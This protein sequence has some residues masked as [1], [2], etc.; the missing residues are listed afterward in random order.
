MV[1]MKSMMK[2]ILVLFVIISTF[3][4]VSAYTVTGM[5]VSP[6]GDF[7]PNTP[8]T[9]SFSIQ[10]AASGDETFP[11]SNTL[12]LATDLENPTW[13]ADLLKNGVSNPQPMDSKKI[14]EITGWILSYDPSDI[15]EENL[16][17]TLSGIAPEVT[18]TTDKNI[19]R[20][21][22]YDSR[23]NVVSGSEV[24]VTR[25]IINTKEITDLIASR[26]TD[27]LA[28]R[29]NI[30][31]KAALEVDIAEAEA[32]Y[33]EAQAAIN[34][35]KSRPS[36]EYSAALASLN[37]AQ[38]LITDGEKVLN[39]AWAEKDIADAQIPITKTDELIIWLKPNATS[40]DSKSQFTQIT[41]KR[42]IAA[43]LITTANDEIFAGNYDRAREKASEAFAK[44]NETYNEAL[45]LQRQLL[46]GW[47]I[48]PNINIK[49]PGG[50]FVIIAVV[51]VVV[52]GVVGYV[53]YRKRTQWD[54]L[55]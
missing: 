1:N 52:L 48:I 19:I 13:T 8:V 18:S 5:S 10:F 41:T 27:L 47:N 44:G 12:E 24:T 2:W 26:E 50:S 15:S 49:L 3:P 36:S 32:K 43:G 35:A 53:I 46:T 25:K 39:K 17:V 22:E 42:E 11:S 40:G 31:E 51:I 54:E 28:F 7:T 23:N 55:G 20:V 37:T 30:D 34:D 6:S 38:T 16:Q 29:T 21:R 45:T 9:V 14:V 4:V 33:S